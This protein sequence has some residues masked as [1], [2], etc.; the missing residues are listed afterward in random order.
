MKIAI[1]QAYNG[2]H[3]VYKKH[4]RDLGA[5][6]F[7]FNIDKDDW[8]KV[9]EKKV[10]A[11]IWHADS[12]EERYM[13]VLD[14]IYFIENVF[15]KPIFPDSKMYFAEGNKVRQY[16]IFES[17]GIAAPKTYVATDK[18]KALKIVEKIKYPC[19]LKDPYGYGGIHVFKVENEK[20]AK[21][22][23]NKIF[24]KGLKTGCSLCRDILYVQEYVEADRDLRVI[25][26]GGKVF[27]AYWRVG[28]DWKHNL[29]QGGEVD[30][31]GVPKKALKMCEEF[32]K[33]MGWHWMGFD[34]M[35]DKNGKIKMIEYSCRTAVKGAESGGYDVRR[36]Q[37]EYLINYFKKHGKKK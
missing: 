6:A 4:L 7:L 8:Y 21:T 27:C 14:K 26:I 22:F 20:Q 25:V 1:G 17:L 24:G 9:G 31:K 16:Q 33:K 3:K 37:M 12:K 32:A 23:V 34:L 5:D 19:I 18:G 29:E 30:F 11:Y 13:E 36:A 10:D 28:E 2:I 15:N 35:Q